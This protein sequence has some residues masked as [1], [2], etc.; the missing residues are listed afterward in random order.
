[1]TG[2]AR[3]VTRA[4]AGNLARRMAVRC[5]G[6][7]ADGGLPRVVQIRAV[8]V[9]ERAF[10]R[11]MSRSVGQLV[12]ALTRFEATAFPRREAT[13]TDP[14]GSSWLAVWTDDQG[15][16][17]YSLRWLSLAARGG[18]DRQAVAELVMLAAQSGEVKRQGI[19]IGKPMGR[20]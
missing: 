15:H 12:F 2:Q 14:A 8:K 1:M 10:Y 17:T 9:L 11:L 5:L 19:P 18:A 7:Q 13:P 16:G 3:R 6:Y 4:E 20:A